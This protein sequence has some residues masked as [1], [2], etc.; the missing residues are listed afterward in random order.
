MFMAVL[1]LLHAPNTSDEF[2][3]QRHF[4]EFG[5]PSKSCLIGS[6]QHKPCKPCAITVTKSPDR[7]QS[8]QSAR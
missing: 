6:H 7:N 5:G 8:F 3:K 1:G 4:Q 2:V